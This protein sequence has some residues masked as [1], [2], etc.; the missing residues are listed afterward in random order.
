MAKN[1][2]GGG[3]ARSLYLPISDTE[4]ELIS[5]LADANDFVIII[6]GWGYVNEPRLTFGDKNLHFYFKMSFDRPENPMAVHFFDLELKTRSGVSL[7]RQKMSTEYGGQPILISAG[8]ELDLVWD[9]SIKNIDPKLVKALMPGVVG[10]TS[11]LQDTTTG[12]IT[13]VGNMKLDST[14]K[15]VLLDLERRE[16]ALPFLERQWREAARKKPN[17]KK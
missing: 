12:D 13:S 8:V 1:M 7:F 17:P 15:R 10:L 6:H 9:I 16:K 11:R 4:Q 3:N 5:R 14:Q 2:F